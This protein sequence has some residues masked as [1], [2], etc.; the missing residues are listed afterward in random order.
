MHVFLRMTPKSLEFSGWAMLYSP[1]EICQIVV[2]SCIFH[3]H[4]LKNTLQDEDMKIAFSTFFGA[5]L[6]PLP[7]FHNSCSES[8]AKTIQIRHSNKHCHQQ[9]LIIR[10]AENPKIT[11]NCTTV[12]KKKCAC[13]LMSHFMPACSKQWALFLHS[14]QRRV[15]KVWGS[16][17]I[18]F[19]MTG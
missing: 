16:D 7:Y 11:N 1:S 8:S 10:C 5:V 13:Q 2:V 9:V 19:L 14:Q 12:T 15:T 6:A 18:R 17:F 3:N 4:M